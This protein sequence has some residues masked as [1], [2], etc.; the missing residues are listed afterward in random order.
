MDTHQ[1][2]AVQAP[3]QPE[4]RPMTLQHIEAA[5][6][7]FDAASSPPWT[8]FGARVLYGQ[9]KV[10]GNRSAEGVTGIVAECTQEPD[11][12]C[13]GNGFLACVSPT[14]DLSDLEASDLAYDRQNQANATFIAHAPADLEAAL[15]HVQEANRLLACLVEWALENGHLEHQTFTE[16]MD[17]LRQMDPVPG[18]VQGEEG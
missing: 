12:D 11:P 10:N 16:A 9:V 7:R 1:T 18:P 14:E 2:G 3:A 13:D 17:F 6:D 15:E 8:A 4:P 5:W